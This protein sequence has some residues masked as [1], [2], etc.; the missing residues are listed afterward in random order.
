MFGTAAHMKAVR[1]C[2][3]SVFACLFHIAVWQLF[4]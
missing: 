4:Y 2:T 1:I 3:L